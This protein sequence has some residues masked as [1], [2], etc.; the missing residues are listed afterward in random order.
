M[1]EGPGDASSPRTLS[2]VRR[3]PHEPDEAAC[4]GLGRIGARDPHSR[5]PARPVD[6]DFGQAIDLLSQW[7]SLSE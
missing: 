6:F 5:E 4:I 7:L 3:L 2:Q 1:L